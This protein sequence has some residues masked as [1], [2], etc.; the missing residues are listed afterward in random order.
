MSS[1]RIRRNSGPSLEA[2]DLILKIMRENIMKSWV[3]IFDDFVDPFS[4]SSTESGAPFSADGIHYPEIMY[5]AEIE[6]LMSLLVGKS[7]HVDSVDGSGDLKDSGR[8]GDEINDSGG[9]NGVYNK[10]GGEIDYKLLFEQS[11]RELKR[12]EE[13]K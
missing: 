12:L 5:R 10:N 8:V 9:D 11:L 1:L 4:I 6:M 2:A 7:G 3:R 13:D